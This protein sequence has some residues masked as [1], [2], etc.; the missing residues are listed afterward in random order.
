MNKYTRLTFICFIIVFLDQISKYLVRLEIP[1]YSNLNI[2]PFLDF[3]HIRNT[4]VAFGMLQNLPQGFKLPFFILVFV[5]A[6]LVI[7]SII[8]NLDEKD[9]FLITG[10]SMIMAGAIGN[11]IDRFRL[12]YVTDFIDFYWSTHHWPP[13]NIADSSITIGATIV[14]LTGLFIRSKN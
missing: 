13:F 6:V 12:G 11:S 5:L 4:G 9:K 8:K 1:L 10:L 3:T 14:V 2:L 7:F